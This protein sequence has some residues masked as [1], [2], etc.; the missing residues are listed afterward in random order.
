MGLLSNSFL[1]L[2]FGAGKGELLR[3][4]NQCILQQKTECSC[5]YGFGL[6]DRGKNRLKA[7]SK[8]ISDSETLQTKP[9][10]KRSKIDIKDLNLINF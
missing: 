8:I 2:E 7:D 9:Q 5:T 10:I 4:L 6:I 1:Y 3:Y